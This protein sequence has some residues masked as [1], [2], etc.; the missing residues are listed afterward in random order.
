M[1]I[2]T[3]W[4]T[5]LSVEQPWLHQVVL[6][7]L[8]KAISVAQLI[9]LQLYLHVLTCAATHHVPSMYSV[10]C[11]LYINGVQG[12]LYTVQNRVFSVHCPI[13]G[14]HCTVFFCI[15]YTAQGTL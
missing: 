4:V 7:K 13:N 10:R 9:L 5:T 3:Y 14:V 11:T 12:T 2:V 1:N 8:V 6:T 15:Q